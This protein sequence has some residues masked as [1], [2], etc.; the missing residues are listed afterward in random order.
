MGWYRIS[1]I[2]FF[3]IVAI[4]SLLGQIVRRR[5]GA[6]VVDAAEKIEALNTL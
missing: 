3:S 1:K 5:R 6:R 2:R 4:V